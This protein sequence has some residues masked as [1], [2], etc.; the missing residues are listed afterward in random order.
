[1][2]NINALGIRLSAICVAAALCTGCPNPNTYGTPRTTP[3]GKI[4]HSLA[5]EGFGYSSHDAQTDTDVSAT[6]PT[7]P[8]YTLRVGLTE[9]LDVGARLANLSS[10]GADVKW[11]FLKSDAFDM[12]LDPGFQAFY[13][14]SSSGGTSTSIGVV[15]LNAPLM[16]GINLGDSVSIVPTLGVTYGIA[17]A[18]VSGSSGKDS[19][20]GSTGIMLRPGLGFDFRISERFAIHPEVTFLKTLKG[21]NEDSALL[22]M[23][24]L[25]FNFGN[26]PKY[27][28]SN[29]APAK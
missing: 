19:A 17:T 14:S 18:S 24:G 11:N 13:F 29:E 22:Y 21:S 6:W 27:G 16:F 7:F 3:V 9:N 8:T 28:S 12:A 2:K 4:Q 26:L 15:Y 23:A 1:M 10:V 5:A 25:G 20:T